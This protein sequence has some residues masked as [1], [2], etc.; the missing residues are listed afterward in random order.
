[1]SEITSQTRDE[2]LTT[3]LALAD[4]AR[5]ATL[6]HFRDGALVADNKHQDGFDPVTAADR[7]A[8]TAMRAVLARLRPEDA[9]LGEEF[10]FQPGSSGLTWVLDPVDGTR[11]FLSGTPTWGVLIAVGD[12]AGPRLGLIDQP[13]IGER[14]LGGF[15]EAWAE[16]P[17]GRR[18]LATRAPR[19]LSEAILFT[20][21]PEVGST[22]EAAAFGDLAGRV[23]LTRYGLDCYAYA[24]VALGQ[25]D[26][27]VEAGLQAYDIQAPM[28]VIE[29][30]GGV[31][32]DWR[33]GSA[34]DGGR[35]LAAANAEI[36]A[37]ALEVLSRAPLD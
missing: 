2:L 11:A 1:M 23:K 12:D 4:A 36:H 18:P 26:L 19:P 9:I 29:A 37:A 27:V 10:G 6:A 7:D 3:A 8:E 24:L 22:A 30:A 28:A 25:I 16:G 5:P 34:R 35:V 17:Q 33:G 14:F 15:G 31:V 32:T 20:T 13:F 21:F